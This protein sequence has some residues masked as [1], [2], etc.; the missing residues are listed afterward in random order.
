MAD[1]LA[2]RAI[3]N[4]VPEVEPSAIPIYDSA[5]DAGTLV[6]NNLPATTPDE[7]YN[8]WVTTKTGDKPV[9]VGRLP[10][11]NVR[12]GESFDFRL[13]SKA[14]VPSGF[15]LTRDRQGTPPLPSASS[16]VLQGPR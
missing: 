4:S 14:T 11:S 1:P 8:L 16:T 13:G 3:P 6:V 9:Y 5:R 10:E 2:L 12:G 7:A 15:I